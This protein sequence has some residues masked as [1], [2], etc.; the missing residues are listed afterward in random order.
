MQ[1]RRVFI[2]KVATSLAGGLAANASA[3]GSA[4]VRIRIG[5]IGAGDRGK[6]ILREAMGCPGVECAGI[7]DVYPRRLEE[8][9]TIAPSAASYADYRALLDD[10]SV[11]AVLIATP[12]HLRGEPFLAALGAG[13][14]IYLEK[15]M[16]LTV[17][18]AKNMRAAWQPSGRTVQ[19]GHQWTSSG[20]MAD[21][22]AF[23]KPELMGKIFTIRAHMYRNTP[24][25]K[26]Q[27]TRPVYPDMT[28]ENIAWPA[29]LGEAPP[30]P[31]DANRFVNWR[32]YWDYSGGAVQEHMCQQV[33]F[34]YK[35]LGLQIPSAVTMTGGLY[36]WK[37]G[38]QTPDT[39]HVSM[40]LPEELLFTWDSGFAND[41]L[42]TGEEA[43]GSDGTISRGQQI[44]YAPQKVNRPQGNEMS[45]RTLTPPRAHMQNFFDC[46]RTGQEPNCP[47]EL[48]YRV[49]VACRMAVESY[50]LGRTVRWNAEK[51]EIV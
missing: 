39:M 47:V 3:A 6:E 2:S 11:D 17:A 26:P 29:F 38:R 50:R 40:E 44:R 22:A 5:L 32:S 1:S 31:F 15:A 36:V 10:K 41:K 42:G 20:Q 46:A 49:A 28:A 48:G 8:A 16:A 24:H 37:D 4:N 13:K 7:A 23:L 18:E 25:G 19:I 27:G 45:G 34:W 9:R 33:A 12:Q 51:E 21:A 43:L 14:H 35:A 30:H